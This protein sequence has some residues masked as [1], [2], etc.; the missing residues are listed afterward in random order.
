MP[1]GCLVF[2]EEKTSFAVGHFGLAYLLGIGL[3]KV[4]KTYVNIPIL[5]VL[6]I[7]PDVDLIYDFFM[8]TEIHRGPTHSIII[9][10]LAFI[11]FFIL[12]RKKAIPYFAALSSHSLIGDFLVAGHVQLL[13]PLNEHEFCIHCDLG[14]PYIGVHSQLNIALELTLFTLTLIILLKTKDIYLFFRNSKTNLLLAIPILTVLLPSLLSFPVYVPFTLLL[15][16]LFYLILFGVSV[17]V[18][19]IK[20]CTKNFTDR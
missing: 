10:I 13:W 4:L 8:K 2:K 12:Y 15:P 19:I 3:A 9:A 6:S 16:H 17:F 5:L 14:L 7:L 1:V 20:T 18:P 11:P